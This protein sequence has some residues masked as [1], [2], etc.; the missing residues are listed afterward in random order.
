VLRDYTAMSEIHAEL[1][2]QCVQR[3]Y[4][5]VG[6]LCGIDTSA[7]FGQDRR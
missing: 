4:S 3:F 7:N 5:N 1:I 6:D 2:L